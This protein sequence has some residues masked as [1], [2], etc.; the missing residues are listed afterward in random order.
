M[1]PKWIID[2]IKLKKSS[3]KTDISLK[4]IEDIKL[5][6]Q[7]TICYEAKCPNKGE[8]FSNKHAT[9]LILGKY[10]TRNCSFCSVEKSKPLPPDPKEPQKIA[11]LVKKWKLKYVVFTSP[12]RDDLDDGGANHFA[13]VI[14]EI[15]K[16]SPSTFIEPLIPDFSLNL[17]NLKIV[18]DAQPTVLAHNIETVERLYSKIRPKSQY[19]VSLKLLKEVKNINPKIPTKSSIIVGMGETIDEV[20]KTIEDLKKN[21]CDILVIGQYLKPSQQSIEV[22]RYY[23]IEE[24]ERLKEFAISIGF[25]AVVSLPLARSSYKAYELYISLNNKGVQNNGS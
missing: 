19:K 21:N 18:I 15:K 3:L 10:C 23:T 11:D 5:Y 6:N 12:T 16:T 4:T 24:F 20:K 17:D 2:E 25:R 8:C 7:N 22:V 13:R 1:Y 14:N 9:F